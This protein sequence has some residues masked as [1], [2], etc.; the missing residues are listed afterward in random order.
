VALRVLFGPGNIADQGPAIA[1]ALRPLGVHADTFAAAPH[2]FYPPADLQHSYT[3]R[4]GKVFAARAFLSAARRY[5][6]IHLQST[7]FLPPF[8]VL[9]P[10]PVE[11]AYIAAGTRLIERL[12]LKGKRVAITFHGSDVR[13]VS[14]IAAH[15]DHADEIL[16]LDSH[17]AALREQR[18]RYSLA[19]GDA[20][21]LVCVTTPDLLPHVPDAHLTPVVPSRAFSDALGRLAPGERTPRRE[22]GALRV[23][24]APSNR[25]IKGSAYVVTAVEAARRRGL[26]VDLVLLSG[27]PTAR[28]VEGMLASDVVVD[29]V[30]FGWYSAVA[31]E[32]MALGR[33]AIARIDPYYASLFT[34]A[35]E[36]SGSRNG[37][38]VD[39]D[40]ERL[41]ETLEGL[42]DMGNEAW[43]DLSMRAISTYESIHRPERVARQLLEHYEDSLGR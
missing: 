1:R 42:F 13:P 7:A 16:A 8:P 18:I 25:T 30:N 11:Q 20:C 4:P 6:V 3:S 41:G 9:V 38:P 39:S 27:L 14:E 15:W 29:Q 35:L 22:P 12:Q 43:H 32:S 31:V 10:A 5:D 34:G 40:S 21:D 26:P 36:Y 28:V 2:A 24:H 19:L 37:M 23:L 17:G 33:P